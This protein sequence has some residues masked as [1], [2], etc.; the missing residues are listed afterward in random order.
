MR[1]TISM[2]QSLNIQSDELDQSSLKARLANAER[3]NKTRSLLLVL[4]LLAFIVVFF[5]L[6]IGSMLIRSIQNPTLSEYMPQTSRALQGWSSSSLP[7]EQVFSTLST[8]MLTLARE[9]QL[10]RVG[11]DLNR[12]QSG[13]KSLFS[14]TARELGKAELAPGSVTSTMIGIDSRWGKLATWAQLKSMA[15]AYSSI[16]YLAAL[17]LQ[18]DD[19]GDVGRQPESRRIYGNV[20]L[21]TL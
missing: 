13:L 17:D 1:G 21:K 16:H 12:V 19:Q 5:L 14:K 9:Q 3:I 4:P 8:E 20:L 10:D 18:Y 7:D 11:S 2:N 15:P 6:P